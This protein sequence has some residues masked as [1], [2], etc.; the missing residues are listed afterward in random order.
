MWVEAVDIHSGRLLAA[1]EADPAPVDPL[2]NEASTDSINDR[3]YS[4]FVARLDL[5]TIEPS[6]GRRP[7]KDA[8]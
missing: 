4:A 1:S 3:S 8:D 5:T 2:L 7:N 6:G